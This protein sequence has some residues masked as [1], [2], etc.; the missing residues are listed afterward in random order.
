LPL[1]KKFKMRNLVID[2]IVRLMQL[3][4]INYDLEPWDRWSN[5]ELLEFYSKLLIDVE[6][7]E[8]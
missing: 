6:T 4:P 2:E 3:V 7:E 1:K 8:Y 5:R